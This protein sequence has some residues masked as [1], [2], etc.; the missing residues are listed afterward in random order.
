M[1]S[2]SRA[3]ASGGEL[4][5]SLPVARRAVASLAP[6]SIDGCG[7][8]PTVSTAV[9]T[10]AMMRSDARAQEDAAAVQRLQ[11]AVHILSLS[12]LYWYKSTGVVY[13]DALDAP[14]QRLQEAVHSFLEAKA[15][16]K[17]LLVC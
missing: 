5:R 6:V 4:L 13:N 11:E 9:P 14:T 8:P 1:W 10:D 3:L 16:S 15:K 17:L 7:L 2:L 12:L